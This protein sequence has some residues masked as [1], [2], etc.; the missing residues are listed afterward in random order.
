MADDPKPAPPAAT[1][2]PRFE[3]F[4]TEV[5]VRD[6]DG[7]SLTLFEWIDTARAARFPRERRSTN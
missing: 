2:S 3:L 1:E 4:M 7:N 6:R 5:R